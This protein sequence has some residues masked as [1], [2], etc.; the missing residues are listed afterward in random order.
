[1]RFEIPPAKASDGSGRTGGPPEGCGLEHF[2]KLY[3]AVPDLSAHVFGE[4]GK[5]FERIVLQRRNTDGQTQNCR[6]GDP[7]YHWIAR[8]LPAGAFLA[9]IHPL[10]HGGDRRNLLFS[11]LPD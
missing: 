4:A 3:L 6:S 2:D 7:L 11:A 9:G 1:M 10:E 8:L 5:T